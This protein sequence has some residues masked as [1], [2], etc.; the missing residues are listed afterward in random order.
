M[1]WMRP[2][3]CDRRRPRRVEAKQLREAEHGVEGGPEFVAHPRQE[4]CLGAIRGLEGR[5]RVPLGT[6]EVQLGDVTQDDRHQHAAIGV[7]LGKRSLERKFVAVGA[8]ADQLVQGAGRLAG[9]HADHESRR[10]G[11]R[12]SRRAIRDEAIDRAA[13]RFGRG[14]AEQRLGGAVEEDDAPVAVDRDDAVGDRVDELDDAKLALAQRG[15]HRQPLADVEEG[16]HGPVDLAR[17]DDRMRPV[18][19]REGRSVAAPERELRDVHLLLLRV[20][21]AHRQR[22]GCAARQ[23]RL[24]EIVDLGAEQLAFIAVA[25][26]LQRGPVDERAL[27]L[28]V[29]AEQALGGGV[30]QALQGLLAVAH[31]VL[32][33]RLNAR[34]AAH[35]GDAARRQQGGQRGVD[36]QEQA[37]RLPGRLAQ[38][39][40]ELALELR[41]AVV[42]V[43]RLGAHFRRR[44]GYDMAAQD[45]L[46]RALDELAHLLD[47]DVGV[48]PRHDGVGHE[49]DVVEPSEQADHAA[50]V[51]AMIAA[52]Q[53]AVARDREV[54]VG[55][56]QLLARD[57]IAER[58]CERLLETAVVL[59]L[60]IFGVVEQIDLR[61]LLALGV[62]ALAGHVGAY[63]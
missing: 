52:L 5:T 38:L 34:G 13:Y 37:L 36:D 62:E 20:G 17:L 18:L 16:R 49:W 44:C 45:P 6:R 46:A 12:P 51:V 50:D 55:P 21:L 40:R 35:E 30:E 14:D 60:V 29:D 63:R 8:R 57:A 53:E 25:E 15:L 41:Q 39:R 32:G 31:L 43:E 19:D 7:E 33:Q 59:L 23:R 54:G 47:D 26:H 11:I 10:C 3:C 22:R 56:L 24:D 27:A 9:V 1:C 58:D 48:G 28:R 4:L 61:V 2:S 42:E